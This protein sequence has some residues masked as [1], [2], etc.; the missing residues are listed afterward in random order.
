MDAGRA[1]AAEHAVIFLYISLSPRF[2]LR[3]PC[4]K[5]LLR[6]GL[7]FYAAEKRAA[8]TGYVLN[9]ARRSGDGRVSARAKSR[10]EF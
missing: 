10:Q 1:L 7:L 5:T 4:A 9:S 8:V 2:C 3:E 6:L